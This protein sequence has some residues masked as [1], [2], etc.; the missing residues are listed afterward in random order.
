VILS[1]QKQAQ[2][3]EIREQLEVVASIMK[4]PILESEFRDMSTRLLDYYGAPLFVIIASLPDR[5]FFPAAS[6]L[7]NEARIAMGIKPFGLTEGIIDRF[8]E[9]LVVSGQNVN[10]AKRGAAFMKRA[11]RAK[12]IPAEKTEEKV[13]ALALIEDFDEAP[14]DILESLEEF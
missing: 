2:L 11:I 12:R 3:K 7:E 1:P 10:V 4:V 5:R 14:K 8:E 6:E 13:E 9:E